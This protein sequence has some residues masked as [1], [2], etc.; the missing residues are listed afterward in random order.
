MFIPDSRAFYGAGTLVSIGGEDE[1]RMDLQTPMCEQWVLL[2]LLISRGGRV[3]AC[4][5][6]EAP[7]CVSGKSKLRTVSLL[8]CD[9]S[10]PSSR[11]KEVSICRFVFSLSTCTCI[12][13]VSCNIMRLFI[14]SVA[15]R[16]RAF[17]QTSQCHSQDSSPVP[18]TATV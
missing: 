12:L 1:A 9:A 2:S 5:T 6:L 3:L 18:L 4:P 11:L 15:L 17:Y 10:H 14:P 16:G 7:R 8:G 13:K